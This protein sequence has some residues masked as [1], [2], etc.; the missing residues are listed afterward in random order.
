MNIREREELLLDCFIE[1]IRRQC[2]TLGME[3]IPPEFVK[4]YSLSLAQSCGAQ[5]ED[6]E[7]LANFVVGSWATK[8]VQEII[9]KSFL[10]LDHRE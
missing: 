10:V 4:N 7:I 3:E 1:S 9:K 8:S 2:K 6:A 5:R